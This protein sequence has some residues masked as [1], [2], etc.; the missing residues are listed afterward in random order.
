MPFV[1]LVGQATLK[2]ALEMLAVDPKLGGVLIRGEKGTAKSTAARG[3]ARLLPEVT[4]NAG[5]PFGCPHDRPR[6]WCHQCRE[7][8]S[9]ET[10]TR[11]PAFETL[12]LG[13]TED[14]L[15]G[16]IDL[17]HVLRSGEQ[18]FAPGLLARVNGGVLYVDE[19]NLLDDHLVDLLLDVAASGVNIVAREGVAVQ[20]PAE[21]MLVGTMNPD[22][23]ELRPQLQDRFGLCVEVRGLA[24]A[25]ER[26]DVV[27][28]YL[29]FERDPDGFAATWAGEE[30]ATRTRIVAAR[31]LLAQIE[32]ARSWCRAAAELALTLEV[33]GHR[34]DLLLVKGAATVAALNGRTELRAEDMA[35][36]ATVVFPHRLRRE[37][38]AERVMSTDELHRTA[39]E[40]LDRV[41]S[42]APPKKK[43]HPR[44]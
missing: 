2:L 30:Q 37:P 8:G 43:P 25:E 21:L 10:V 26:A 12:P 41:F 20:H 38:F 44:P 13:T 34:A 39:S 11:R 4:L 36:A 18:R 9:N 14:Q 19:V 23:G 32:P 27:E 40:V 15:L 22:E 24:D 33:D 3:L 29:A 7:N 35:R 42:D 5:C 6:V 16:T 28:R 1:A 17:E 31:P